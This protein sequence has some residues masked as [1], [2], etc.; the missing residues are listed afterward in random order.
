MNL[1][2]VAGVLIL[3]EAGRSIFTRHFSVV[4]PGDE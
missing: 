3:P 4:N 2:A 1:Y